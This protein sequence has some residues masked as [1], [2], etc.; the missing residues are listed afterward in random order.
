MK[1][2]MFSIL[3]IVF[4]TQLKAQDETSTWTYMNAKGDSVLR[5]DISKNF[6]QGY[7]IMQAYDEKDEPFF[8]IIDSTGATKKAPP[9]VKSLVERNFNDGLIVVSNSEDKMGLMDTKGKL[10]VPM[11]YDRIVGFS[12]GLSSASKDGKWGYIDK[13]GKVVIALQYNAATPFESGLAI[14]I[15]DEKSYILDKTGKILNKEP[16]NA[17]ETFKG[18]IM[19]QSDNEKWALVDKTGKLVTPYKYA[20]LNSTDAFEAGRVLTYSLDNKTWGLIT[21]DGKELTQPLYTIGRFDPTCNCA[22]IRLDEKMG[23]VDAKGKIIVPFDYNGDINY[24]IYEGMLKVSQR[25][26]KSDYENNIFFL[27]KTGKR[28]SDKNYDDVYYFSEGLAAVSKDGLWG[29]IDK[30]GKE[31]IPLKYSNVLNFSEGLAAVELN[32][33]TGFIDAKGKEVIP[34]QFDSASSFT[35]GLVIVKKGEKNVLMDK[36]GKIIKEVPFQGIAHFSGGLYL[37][38]KPQE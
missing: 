11:E 35:N 10:V 22:G 23:Y 29:F 16:F 1:K 25:K 13:N 7:I 15:K 30:T 4:L 28:I 9:S 37:T 32:K 8:N 36:T 5:V 18:C 20:S 24:V 12:D 31:V 2:T 38:W 14:V 21:F 19:A 33:K 17:A 27:D 26:E 6:N 3:C 34:F